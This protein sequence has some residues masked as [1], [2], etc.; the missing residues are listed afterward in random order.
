M[1][2]D[3]ERPGAALNETELWRQLFLAVVNGEHE[4]RLRL[5]ALQRIA[6]LPPHDCQPCAAAFLDSSRDQR[7]HVAE[8]A[9]GLWKARFLALKAEVPQQRHRLEAIAGLHA[10]DLSVRFK[11][12]LVI[13]KELLLSGENGEGWRVPGAESLEEAFPGEYRLSSFQEAVAAF[14]SLDMST[15]CPAPQTLE[16]MV[17]EIREEMLSCHQL[18]ED[19]GYG[20]C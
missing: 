13:C 17:E 20:S 9:A 7:L 3:V 11:A 12:W 1:L 15:G 8:S 10:Y 18:W 16:S 6:P 4:E 14:Q 2:N 19:G 5:S